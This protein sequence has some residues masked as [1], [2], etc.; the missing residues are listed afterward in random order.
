MNKEN[1]D[2][3]PSKRITLVSYDD[4][5]DYWPDSDGDSGNGVL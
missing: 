2:H 3:P 4:D 1:E 5:S